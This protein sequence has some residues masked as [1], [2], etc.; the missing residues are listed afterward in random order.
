M[1]VPPGGDTANMAV[2]S[3]TSLDQRERRR[4]GAVAS[5]RLFLALAGGL[6]GKEMSQITAASTSSSVTSTCG[7]VTAL[8]QASKLQP[9]LWRDRIRSS[10]VGRHVVNLQR[11]GAVPR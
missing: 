5:A 9:R 8:A 11:T 10:T 6:G 1:T 2:M 7:C 3:R 4:E